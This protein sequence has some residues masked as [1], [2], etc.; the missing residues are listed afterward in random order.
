MSKKIYNDKGNLLLEI[1]DD[2]M[3]AQLTIN[4]TMDFLDEKEIADLLWQAGI[5]N[6]ITEAA[7]HVR[8]NG[9]LKT[10]DSPFPV[11][12]CQGGES[13]TFTFNSLFNTEELYNPNVP[14]TVSN[15][16]KWVYV[17]K[18]E[19]IAELVIPEADESV[20]IFG[21]RL[22]GMKPKQ[23][24]LRDFLGENVYFSEQRGM[25]LASKTGYPYI[26][27]TGRV[28]VI[29]HFILDQDIHSE[30][31]D[32]AIAGNLKITGSVTGPIKI[33]VLGSVEIDGSVDAA[34]IQSGG[35]LSI[36]GS[37]TNANENGVIAL[38]DLSFESAKQSRIVS[39]GYI[40]FS[41]KVIDCRMVAEKGING[42]ANHSVLSGGEIQSGGSIDVAVIGS[43]DY[44]DTE[45]EVTISPFLKE[46]MITLTKEIIR[47]KSDPN[48]TE[49]ELREVQTKMQ[50]LEQELD[51]A[52]NQ[53]IIS[54][55]SDEYYI[56][57]HH[58][59]YKG[60]YLRILKK[61]Y[62][63]MES[64]KEFELK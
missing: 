28:H 7:A 4:S 12:M 42:N 5:R 21:N 13:K 52:I 9:I 60:S 44:V 57:A 25:I 40:H 26:D 17:E 34:Y 38:G 6:G 48:T 49:D 64:V 47:R 30:Y 51:S 37:I 53:A 27:E 55:A 46:K 56:K 29:G 63:A 20:D 18:E 11:A 10:F 23:E 16:Q 3:S 54:D 24:I 31:G 14:L 45:V 50:T 22:S 41:G 33:Q 2:Q 43:P 62:T 58:I 36:K 8:K 61:S 32:I 1:A 15:T 35:S 39:N 19:P 59:L